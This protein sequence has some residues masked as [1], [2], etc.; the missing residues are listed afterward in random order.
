[1]IL[2]LF[3]VFAGDVCGEWRTGKDPRVDG[4]SA[5]IAVVGEVVGAFVVRGG[6]E[7]H[8][9]VAAGGLKFVV[10]THLEY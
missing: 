4:T 7:T 2:D 1:M 8:L 5:A 6:S 9:L 10:A 3:A